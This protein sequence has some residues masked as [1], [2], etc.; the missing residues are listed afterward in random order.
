MDTVNKVIEEDLVRMAPAVIVGCAINSGYNLTESGLQGVL[1]EV[2][3]PGFITFFGAGMLAN[4]V[5]RHA[6]ITATALVSYLIGITIFTTVQHIPAVRRAT[7]IFPVLGKGMLMIGLKKSK[8][9]LHT[10][11]AWFL[12]LEASGLIIGRLVLDK[13]KIAVSNGRLAEIFILMLGLGVARKYS[14]PDVSMLGLVLV[15]SLLPLL[16]KLPASWLRSRTAAKL[17]QRKAAQPA[18]EE[19]APPPGASPKTSPSKATRRRTAVKDKTKPK[20]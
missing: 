20:K 2:L 14:L 16:A 1:T 18:A 15:L 19:T 3:L 17:P 8:E 4:L 7:A 10:V 13:K 11:V 5:F 12:A 9:P 6:E